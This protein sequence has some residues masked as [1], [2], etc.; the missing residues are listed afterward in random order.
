MDRALF[1]SNLPTLEWSEFP[2]A[3]F[4]KPAAGVCYHGS[5]LPMRGGWAGRSNMI[6]LSIGFYIDRAANH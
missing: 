1:P 6:L 5:Q 2:A 4:S 3:G